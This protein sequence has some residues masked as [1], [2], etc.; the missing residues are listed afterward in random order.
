MHSAHCAGDVSDAASNAR[1]VV[2]LRVVHA[3]YFG[4]VAGR[5]SVACR[6]TVS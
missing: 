4:I 2:L 1:F 6:P 5:P 3:P